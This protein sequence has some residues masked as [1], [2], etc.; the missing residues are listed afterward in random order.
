M[1]WCC[2]TSSVESPN[3]ISSSPVNPSSILDPTS[4]IQPT[5]G[6]EVEEVHRSSP[7]N[8]L[9]SA[10]HVPVT[11][12][13]RAQELFYPRDLDERLVAQVYQAKLDSFLLTLILISLILIIVYAMNDNSHDR[14]LELL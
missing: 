6:I 9:Q 8:E 1:F 12:E 10:H 2:M 5:S 14:L 4:V 3:K 7:V 13:S 11:T